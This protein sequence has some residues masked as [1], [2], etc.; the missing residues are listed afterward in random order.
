MAK[1]EEK[2]NETE[3]D[4]ETNEEETVVV[5]Q[6]ESTKEE[7]TKVNLEDLSLQDLLQKPEVKQFVEKARK[8]EKDKLYDEIKRKEDKVKAKEKEIKDMETK[9]K[10]LETSLEK[11]EEEKSAIKDKYK[12]ILDDLKEDV[13]SMKE[14]N[15]TLGLE[16]YKERKIRELKEEGKG[17]IESIV[18]GDS[19]E[20]IDKS[21]TKAVE[22][23]DKIVEEVSTKEQKEKELKEKEEKER[24]KKEKEEAELPNPTNPEMDTGGESELNISDI[25]NM[26]VEE[27]K[28]RRDE[29]KRRMGIK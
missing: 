19:K 2:T 21:I 25:D 11:E 15:K 14:E 22:E 4:Q 29:I 9:I 5:K 28:E 26:S 17:L 10:K 27:W 1:P 18:G 6:S 13:N 3:V 16:A 7:E 20:E 23:Y 8:Q 24:K 12:T